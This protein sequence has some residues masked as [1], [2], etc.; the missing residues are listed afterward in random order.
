MIVK[1]LEITSGITLYI[2]KDLIVPHGL[3]PYT[4][5]IIFYPSSSRAIIIDHPKVAPESYPSI[6][7]LPLLYS[8]VSF[9]NKIM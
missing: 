2:Q 8:K 3:S 5:F 9:S 6:S 7:C 1:K 4:I